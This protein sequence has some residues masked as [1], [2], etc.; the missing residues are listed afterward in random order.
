[1]ECSP[2]PYLAPL[3]YRN[4]SRPTSNNPAQ[5]CMERRL[6]SRISVH[7]CPL[8]LNNHPNKD[9]ENEFREKKTFEKRLAS[10]DLK[11]LDIRENV[12]VKDMKSPAVIKVTANTPRSC[13][14]ETPKRETIR[15]NYWHLIKMKEGMFDSETSFEMLLDESRVASNITNC[16][17]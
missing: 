6:R 4:T 13:I 2:D 16:K 5:L 10:H 15:Q 7:P 11:P 8:S 14:A 3:S 9:K 12:W 17:L 1:M